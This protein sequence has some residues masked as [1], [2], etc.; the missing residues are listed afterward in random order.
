MPQV[1]RQVVDD[2]P[3][4]AAFSAPVGTVVAYA[5]QAEGDTPDTTPPKII[6]L[7]G[8]AFVQRGRVES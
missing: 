3:K 1:K 8:V 7:P 4:I 2:P 5:G 6:E